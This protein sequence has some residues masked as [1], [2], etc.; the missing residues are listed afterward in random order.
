MKV[1]PTREPSPIEEL[2]GRALEKNHPKLMATES[3]SQQ[4]IRDIIHVPDA[5]LKEGRQAGT[6]I[7]TC[8]ANTGQHVLRKL[9][10]YGIAGTNQLGQDELYV[11]TSALATELQVRPDLQKLLRGKSGPTR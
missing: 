7:I 4:G 8:D 10:I 3:G 2:I 5:G 11:D 1:L 9:G 6:M